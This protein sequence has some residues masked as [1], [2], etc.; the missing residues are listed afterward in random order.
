V[1]LA[2]ALELDGDDDRIVR[3]SDARSGWELERTVG[4]LRRDGL[5]VS[6]GPYEARVLWLD[7]PREPSPTSLTPMEE[8][9]PA[10][11]K[12]PRR[13]RAARSS[14][15]TRP[16]GRSTAGATTTTKKPT[17]RTPTAERGKPKSAAVEPGATG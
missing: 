4:D 11:A 9:E 6:L 2:D 10:G 15:A 14:A 13:R 5:R 12:R 1:R 8:A 3:F 7:Q 17:T 16:L